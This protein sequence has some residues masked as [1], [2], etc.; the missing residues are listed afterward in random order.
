MLV[1]TSLGIAGIYFISSRDDGRVRR[2]STEDALLNAMNENAK[3][4]QDIRNRDAIIERQKE[5]IAGYRK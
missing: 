1:C 4:R 5:I 2:V 3:L